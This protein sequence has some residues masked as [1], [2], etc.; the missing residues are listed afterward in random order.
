MESRGM[1]N[2][3]MRALAFFWALLIMALTGNMIHENSGNT[4]V[5]NYDLFVSIFAMLTLLYLIP[6]TLKESFQVHPLLPLILDILNVIFWFCAAVA[7]AAELGAHSCSNHDYLVSNRITLG[8][9]KRCQEAGASTTF[10]FFGFASFLVSTVLSGLGSRGAANT[11]PGIRR[12]P[13]MS[14]V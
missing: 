4:P 8:S 3:I 9:K 12:G 11:R 2:L 1:I 14:Q 6:A 7:T 10:L 13:A 5:I